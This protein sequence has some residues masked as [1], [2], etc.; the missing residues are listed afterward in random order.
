MTCIIKS[1]IEKAKATLAEKGYTLS[2]MHKAFPNTADRVNFL[3]EQFGDKAE[4]EFF[5]KKYENYLLKKQKDKL[6]EWVK[7]SAKEGIDTTTTKTL[8]EKIDSLNDVFE[9]NKKGKE[10]LNGLIEQKLGFAITQEEAENL[11]VANNNVKATKKALLKKH[12]DFMSWTNEEGMQKFQKNLDAELKAIEESGSAVHEKFSK[13]SEELAAAIKGSDQSITDY[14]AA[15]VALKKIYDDAKVGADTKER[16]KTTGG[17]ISNFI[18]TSLGLIKSIKASWDISF[19]RQ[20]SSAFFGGQ[21]DS[22]LK[23]WKSGL[24][25]FGQ[26]FTASSAKEAQA[27][28]DMV[29]G[30]LFAR[31]NSMNGNYKKLG[32][33]VGIREEA[34]PESVMTK[35]WKGNGNIFFASDAAFNVAIQTARANIAD[36]LIVLG[37]GDIGALKAMAAG[38]YVNQ[39]TG[40]GKIRINNAETERFINSALFSP[41]WLS[42][43]IQTMA[44]SWLIFK[45]NKNLVEKLRAK[46]AFAQIVY[47]TAL[48]MLLKGAMRAID[49]DDKTYGEQAWEKLL[50]AFDARSSDFGKLVWGD[51]RFDTSFGTSGLIVAAARIATG[52]KITVG[53]SKKDVKRSD[54]LGA[55]LEGKMSPGYR[56][57]KD[58]WTKLRD[59]EDAKNF[60]FQPI[61]WGG[62]ALQT[63]API[64]LENVIEQFTMETESRTAAIVGIMLDVVGVGTNTYG[65]DDRDKGKSK[66]LK[67]AEAGLSWRVDRDAS[68]IEPAK[69][70]SI[71]TKLSGD[72]RDSAVEDF[73]KLYNSEATKLVKSPKFK[74]MSDDQKSKALSKVRKDVNKAIK[75]KYGIKPNKKDKK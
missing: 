38:D 35:Y 4:A 60:M 7:K 12:P 22:G 15:V 39:I 62:L 5:N 25:T 9:L 32:I 68:K 66:E 54:V 67:N 53:G 1:D 13:T 23:G 8:L 48:P 34:F 74:K 26:M 71:M 19:G 14:A 59:G 41:R 40:R 27:K 3:T 11:L 72:K 45:G 49:E 33:A 64:S 51:T 65:I 37:N 63:F 52:Q 73:K 44:D 58:V 24:K 46:A 6:R 10:F 31:P 56:A 2:Q 75:K 55:F 29:E 70:S 50:S 18:S 42:S 17:K 20:L 30:L 61:T 43:R 36:N 16:T 57:V 21:F 47:L 28:L 69:T